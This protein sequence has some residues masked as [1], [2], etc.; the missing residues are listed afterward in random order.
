MI[1]FTHAHAHSRRPPARRV[2]PTGGVP[3]VDDAEGAGVAVAAGLLQGAL[4]LAEVHAPALVLV[5]V[6]VD[7]HGAQLGQRR[8]VQR[9][10]GDGDHHA[11]AALVLAAH[12]QLQHGLQGI[13]GHVQT[14]PMA[15]ELGATQ[16]GA[17]IPAMSSN[18][19]I[20][21]Y[22]IIEGN[23]SVSICLLK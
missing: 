8:R 14:V 1:H 15:T 18:A 9:V 6:V 2:L 5:E 17:V 7:L 11:R 22:R 4:Q 12:Q 10:L 21:I 19:Y 3:G 20:S 23:G 13:G 16:C